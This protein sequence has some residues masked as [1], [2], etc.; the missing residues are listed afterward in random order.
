VGQDEVVPGR[1]VTSK[2]VSLLDAFTPATPVLSLNQLAAA[3]GLPLSTAHRLAG[4]LVAWG[5][6]E[7]VEGTGYRIGLRLW[8]VGS[9][10]PRGEDLR[11]VALPVMQDLYEGTHANVHLAV[12]D[13]REA[14]YIEKINGPDA[15]RVRSRRGGRLPLHATGVGKVLLAFA[16]PEVVDAVIAAGLPRYTGRTIIV[17]GHLRRALAEVRRT[18]LAHAYEELTIGSLT[19][20]A[21]ILGAD[22]GVVAALD[23]VVHTTRADARKLGPAVRTSAISISRALGSVP[24]P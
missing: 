8:E 18:G 13:G 9:L 24:P 3:T 1:S 11:S 19:A 10:A 6:L 7:H 14:L 20:A 17:P 22:G 5:G 21:P 12:R 4:E 15:L 23:V 16:P 2:V